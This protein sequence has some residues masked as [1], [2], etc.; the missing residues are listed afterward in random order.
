MEETAQ[1]QLLELA[2]NPAFVGLNLRSGTLCLP[3]G[4]PL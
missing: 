4:E 1:I 2:L 3:V